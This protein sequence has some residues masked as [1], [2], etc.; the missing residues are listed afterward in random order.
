M[1]KKGF[2]LGILTSS[3]RIFSKRLYEE[4]KIKAYVY[5]SRSVELTTKGYHNN[6]YCTWLNSFMFSAGV[7]FQVFHHARRL[8]TAS[9]SVTFVH[10]IVP[11]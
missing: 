1:D 2:M 3:K 11:E 4:G 7:A 8:V 9:S 6:S 10:N 5:Q